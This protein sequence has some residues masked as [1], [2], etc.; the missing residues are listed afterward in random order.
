MNAALPGRNGPPVAFILIGI[1]VLAYFL[2]M[3]NVGPVIM[4]FALWPVSHPYFM[5]WQLVSYGFL[6]GG[7]GHLF[8]NMFALYMFGLPIER[9]WGT[10]RFLI[11][12]FVCMVG[13]GLVQLLVTA[14]T[15]EVYHTIGAS[16]AVFG[17]LLAFGMMYPNSMIMLLIPPIPMKAKYFVII[18]GALTLFFG[19][20]GTMSGVAHFAHLGGMLFGLGL[21]LYWGRQDYHR[22]RRF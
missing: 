18:Y 17:L 11:F 9:A 19:M 22:R 20:T 12:Y 16:G 8:F 4:N 3:A 13:A 7:L 10:R 15:G 1:T 6:H 21:I 14:L 2:E 5:P